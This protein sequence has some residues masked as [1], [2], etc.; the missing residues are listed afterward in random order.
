MPYTKKKKKIKDQTLKTVSSMATDPVNYVPSLSKKTAKKKGQL[1]SY[2]KY[3]KSK[4]RS[5]I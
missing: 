5:K 2:G 1:S 3:L 4:K